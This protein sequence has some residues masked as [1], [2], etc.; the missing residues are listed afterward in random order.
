MTSSIIKQRANEF[1]ARNP[2]IAPQIEA[3]LEVIAKN[4]FVDMKTKFYFSVPPITATLWKQDGLWVL[5]HLDTKCTQIEVWNI[6]KDGDKP[7]VR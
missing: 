2:S 4:P 6:G 3:I 5:Y 7:T 1:I